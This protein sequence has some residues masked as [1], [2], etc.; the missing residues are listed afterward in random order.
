MEGEGRQVAAAGWALNCIRCTLVDS[1]LLYLSYKP[2]CALY[3]SWRR[4]WSQSIGV[5]VGMV[6]LGRRQAARDLS[7]TSLRPPRLG[8]QLRRTCLPS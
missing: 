3:S 8:K 4:V 5:P 1:Q 6:V 2:A 7:R